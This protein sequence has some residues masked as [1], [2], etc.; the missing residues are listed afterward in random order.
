MRSLKVFSLA[1]LAVA[2][3]AEAKVF[4]GDSCWQDERKT[5]LTSQV[6]IDTQPRQTLTS[7]GA[8]GAWYGN[9]IR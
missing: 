2:D 7:F 1:I 6:K 5:M 9:P 3:A 4:K 8:S